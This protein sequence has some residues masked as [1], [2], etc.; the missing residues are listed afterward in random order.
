MSGTEGYAFYQGLDVAPNGRVDVAYQ[1]QVAVDPTTFG[2]G[3]A[4]IDA[5]AVSKAPGGTWSAPVRISTAS[6]DPA[7]S[8][9]NNLQRQFW[10]DYSTLVSDNT[11]AWFIATD[12]RRGA[13]CADVDAYQHYLADNGLV[14][15]SDGADRLT[16]KLTGVNPAASDPRS[17]RHRRPCVRR[18]SATPTWSSLASCRERTSTSKWVN[19]GAEPATMFTQFGSGGLDGAFL[20]PIDALKDDQVLVQLHPD[21]VDRLAHD[22]G[23]PLVV[24]AGHR[25]DGLVEPG[26]VAV[27]AGSTRPNSAMTAG[28]SPE[29]G[30]LG[31]ALLVVRPV[32][33]VV[34]HVLGPHLPPCAQRLQVVVEWEESLVRRA[35]RGLHFV[36]R[37]RHPGLVELLACGQE[38]V[39][40]RPSMWRA[41]PRST[42]SVSTA[43]GT[44]PRLATN[45]S[46]VT[47]PGP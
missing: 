4:S 31:G 3:N 6:S 39:I 28:R 17:S 32:G 37:R 46:G 20:D 21:V 40:C 35:Q 13:G 1:A 5:Y 16:Q 11:G 23:E 42:R 19:K 44:P 12:S 25:G 27:H 26:P 22:A 9:Q 18:T 30:E 38:A 29:L 33:V 34:R 8:A 2:T 7:V 45:P 36:A 47:N 15:R 43:T 41:R 14:I 24:A 10:G